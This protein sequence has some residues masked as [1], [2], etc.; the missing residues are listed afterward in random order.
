M[1]QVDREDLKEPFNVRLELLHCYYEGMLPGSSS[2]VDSV[3]SVVCTGPGIGPLS[4]ASV[5][6]GEPWST[7]TTNINREGK[8]EVNRKYLF[9]R[10]LIVVIGGGL[11]K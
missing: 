3:A 7:I 2:S 11:P 10:L 6:Y 1:V 8:L 9:L 5:C 4:Q